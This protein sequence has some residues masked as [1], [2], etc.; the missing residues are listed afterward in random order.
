MSDFNFSPLTSLNVNKAPRIKTAKFG[1]GYEQR[2][3]DGINT[4]P[5]EWDLRWRNTKS[6]IDSIDAFFATK[7]GLTA[8]TWTPPDGAEIKVLCQSWSK[9][10]INK[11]VYEISG[12]FR[13]VFE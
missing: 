9:N 4:R 13:Q 5:Q 8:F 2:I 3:A 11:N 1:D 7:N 10:L 6:I 12:T